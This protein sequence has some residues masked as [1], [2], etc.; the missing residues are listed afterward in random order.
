MLTLPEVAEDLRPPESFI[1]E[2]KSDAKTKLLLKE[3][4]YECKYEYEYVQTLMQQGNYL[5]VRCHLTVL[6]IQSAL[7]D[8]EVDTQIFPQSL[9]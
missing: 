1:K 5:G 8:N 4:E 9:L 3:Y 2:V 6:Y 7:R